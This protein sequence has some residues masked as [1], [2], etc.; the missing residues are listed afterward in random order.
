M[1]HNMKSL[2]KISTPISSM[3]H[4]D[5][6]AAM[7]FWFTTPTGD[8][9]EMK[10]EDLPPSFFHTQQNSASLGTKSMPDSPLMESL[11]ASVMNNFEALDRL[12][13]NN[14][15]DGPAPQSSLSSPPA[16]SPTTHAHISCTSPLSSVTSAEDLFSKTFNKI[17]K[18]C[19]PSPVIWSKET[20]SREEIKEYPADEMAWMF[21]NDYGELIDTQA[22]SNLPN[23]SELSITQ[24]L[25]RINRAFRHQFRAHMTDVILAQLGRNNFG[26]DDGI[27]SEDGRISLWELENSSGESSGGTPRASPGILATRRALEIGC[28]DGSWCFGLKRRYPALAV[29]GVDDVG[30]WSCVYKDVELR[31]KIIV[32]YRSRHAN[33]QQRFHEFGIGIG[34]LHTSRGVLPSPSRQSGQPRIHSSQPE[35]SFEPHEAVFRKSLWNCSCKR[36]I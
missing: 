19:L 18:L 20:L 32:L 7:S 11:R 29:E 17:P 12:T 6:K 9:L 27:G 13:V 15:L 33:S 35:L 23:S 34:H 3:D 28:S 22:A 4:P 10:R 24:L 14:N 16:Q 26:F 1:L 2:A 30:H 5:N 31:C 21:Y 25:R 36:C 8:D